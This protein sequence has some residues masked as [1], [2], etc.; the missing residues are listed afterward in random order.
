MTA[1]AGSGCAGAVIDL[2]TRRVPNALTIGIAALGIGLAAC[3]VTPIGIGG[4]LAGFAV[5]LVMMLPG[6]LVGATGAGD[7]KLLAAM[8]TLL[9]P[10]GVAMAFIYT[11]LAGG[12]L[13]LVVALSRGRLGVTLD[14]A[15]SLVRTAGAT[16]AEIEHASAD[17]RFAYAP[18]IAVGA[19]VAVLR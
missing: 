3:R 9:G 6:H 4:A 16:V 12:A 13:A 5:G 2:R 11:A 10:A 8:G 1:V 18:A 7:V 19:L 15:A 14:R 17:N